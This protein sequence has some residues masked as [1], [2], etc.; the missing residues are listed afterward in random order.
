MTVLPVVIVTKAEQN[1]RI[2]TQAKP[3]AGL[4]D[5]I[6][7]TQLSG[8]GGQIKMESPWKEKIR[9]CPRLTKEDPKQ[10]DELQ[11]SQNSWMLPFPCEFSDG[12]CPKAF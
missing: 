10:V 4:D 5:P 1:R 3:L 11:S 12:D 7:I 9:G 6:L 2:N 8:I